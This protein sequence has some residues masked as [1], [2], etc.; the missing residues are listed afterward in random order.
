MSEEPVLVVGAGLAGL[1]CALH[2]SEAGV[3]VRLLEAADRAGGRVRTDELQGFRLDRG[4][5]VLL[6]AYPEARRVLDFNTLDLRAFEPGALVR[7]QGRFHRVS[8]PFRRPLSALPGL[9][10]PVGTL[11]D[12]LRVALLRRRVLSLTESSLLAA[13]ERTTEEWLRERGFTPAMVERFLR[14]FFAGVFLEPKLATSSHWFELLFRYFALGEAALPAGGM[15]EIPGQLAARLP[16]E[17][18]R[19]EAE[20]TSATASQVRLGNGETLA[21]RAVV[22]ATEEPVARR[23]LG[24]PEPGPWCSVSCLY[25]AAD[26]APIV[27][28]VL[29]LNGDGRGPINNLCFPSRLSSHYAPAG[30]ELI[31][32]TVLGD[33]PADPLPAVQEQLEEWFGDEVR[34]WSPLRRQ[35][36][37]WALPAQP[38][39]RFGS[40]PFGQRHPSGIYLAGDYLESPSLHGAMLSGRRAAEALVGDLGGRRTR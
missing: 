24:E 7:W 16:A 30:R 2:L 26:R 8:D 23:L 9:F 22:V 6:T 18:L 31:S 1:C 33:P 11:G 21:G 25:F 35:H 17:T 37:R 4:F 19:L 28:P 10:A 40:P 13:E 34:N 38:P 20:V 29:L 3:P 27:D 15:G 39:G 36:I 14:P 12:K 32:V 5:Q